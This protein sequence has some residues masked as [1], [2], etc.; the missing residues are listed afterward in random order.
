[1]ITN[2]IEWTIEILSEVRLFLEELR[3]ALSEK[4]CTI[5]ISNKEIYQMGRSER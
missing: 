2:D 5:I 4:K 1:M 3:L